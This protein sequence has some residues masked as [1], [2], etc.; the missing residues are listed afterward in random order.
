MAV[1]R[2]LVI[3][4]LKIIRANIVQFLDQTNSEM[5]IRE[6]KVVLKIMLYL[7]GYSIIFEKKGR[8]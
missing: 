8:L 7:W 1:I 2:S 5:A 6:G 3:G 4:I